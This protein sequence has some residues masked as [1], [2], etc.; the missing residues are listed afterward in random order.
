MEDIR[1]FAAFAFLLCAV[2]CGENAY[3]PCD[4]PDDCADIPEGATATC[5]DKVG[6]GFCTWACVTDDDCVWDDGQDG[7]GARRC[8]G[9]VSVGGSYCF[10]SCEDEEDTCPYGMECRTTGDGDER[11]TVCLPEEACR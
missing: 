10:P 2:G 7:F 1:R 3:E 8:A 11:R 5:I 4:G 9:L 6:Q